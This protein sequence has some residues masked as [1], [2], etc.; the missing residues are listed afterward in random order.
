MPNEDNFREVQLR[1]PFLEASP[2]FCCFARL[3]WSGSGIDAIVWWEDDGV[4]R[5]KSMRTGEVSERTEPKMLRSEEISARAFDLAMSEFSRAGIRELSAYGPVLSHYD[6][7]YGLKND[8]GGAA[9]WFFDRG[10]HHPGLVQLQNR[11][12]GQVSGVI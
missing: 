6:C 7:W 9:T 10:G 8:S 3:W 5:L 4:L 12:R 11:L 1:L 2:R